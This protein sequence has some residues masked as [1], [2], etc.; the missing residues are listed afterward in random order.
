MLKARA[1]SQGIGIRRDV[2]LALFG[3]IVAASLAM[4]CGG[5]VDEAAAD[6]KG[7]TGADTRVAD[8]GVRADTNVVDTFVAD[9]TFVGA[10]TAIAEDTAVDTAIDTYDACSMPCGC[11]K[12]PPPTV[13]YKSYTCP[14]GM[15]DDM[16][17]CTA[18]VN[19]MTECGPNPAGFGPYY[20]TVCRTL[21]D[22]AGEL[23]LECTW[24]PPPCGRKTEG[25]E[26]CVAPEGVQ[27]WLET[28]ARL[29]AG[30]VDAFV[31]LSREL[32]AA[33][34]PRE[35]VEGARRAAADEVRHA[36]DVAALAGGPP[37]DGGG[38]G[39]FEL[40]ALDEV[41]LENAVEG[42]VR[43]TFGALVAMYQAEAA[44]DPRVRETFRTIAREETAHAALAWE[45]DA[46]SRSRLS[47]RVRMRMDRARR[48]E[49]DKLAREVAIEPSPELVRT[50]GLPP[51]AVAQ[52]LLSGLRRT[53]FQ[54]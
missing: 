28:A 2:L 44:E 31:R 20:T 47:R 52:Q 51:A 46:W 33:G 16:G 21:R 35:L 32:L 9:D 26:S 49:M 29:E 11:Y 5:S 17:N 41:A 23:Q 10:D 22:P 43:E 7:D 8:T 54:C 42:C 48:R 13:V 50:L 6:A 34:A 53:A 45:I 25:Q 3:E 15:F 1:M 37:P 40:R 38:Y 14:D 19:C 39:R 18:P 30:S 12:P 36:R 24:Y 27:G 4:A